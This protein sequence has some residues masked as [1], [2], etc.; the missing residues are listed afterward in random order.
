MCSVGVFT[1]EAK[2]RLSTIRTPVTVF[3]QNGKK[4]KCAAIWDTGADMTHISQS[5]VDG[6]GLIPIGLMS[7]NVASGAMVCNVYLVD[8]LLPGDI[9]IRN[10]NVMGFAGAPNCDILIGMD[11]ICDGDLA[12]TNYA[13]DTWASFLVPALEH[14]DFKALE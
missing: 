13:G 6:L 3:T 10:I 2:G 9:A 14:I 11:V 5:L 4:A 1:L 7:C 8:I 12:I